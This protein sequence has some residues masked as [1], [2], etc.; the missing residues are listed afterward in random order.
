MGVLPGPSVTRRV[1]LSGK[2]VTLGLVFRKKTRADEA[3][4]T[5]SLITHQRGL[6]PP[7]LSPLL[8]PVGGRVCQRHRKGE[9][10]YLKNKSSSVK[11]FLY[12][13]IECSASFQIMRKLKHP[14]FHS[15]KRE[16]AVFIILNVSQTSIQCLSGMF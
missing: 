16:S 6:L 3:G 7:G 1:L 12:I 10:W 11:H 8:L 5:S 2:M 15:S 9:G 14:M 13:P 4:G